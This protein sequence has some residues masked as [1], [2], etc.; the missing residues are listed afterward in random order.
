MGMGSMWLCC[1][2][3]DNQIGVVENVRW[4]W[5]NSKIVSSRGNNTIR[6][7]VKVKPLRASQRDPGTTKLEVRLCGTLSHA[8]WQ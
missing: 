7:H 5:G 3:H 6:G 8:P 2:T 1:G 4:G